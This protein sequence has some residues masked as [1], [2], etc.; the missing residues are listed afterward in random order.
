MNDHP[1]A[2][3][4]YVPPW[5]WVAGWLATSVA[6]AASVQHT[7]V[8]SHWHDDVGL[9]RIL[10]RWPLGAQGMISTALA[11]LVLWVPVGNAVYRAA[12]VANVGAAAAGLVFFQLLRELLATNA[13]TPRLGT[14]LAMLGSMLL[15]LGLPMQKSA[16]VAG[17]ASRSG[18]FEFERDLASC[19]IVRSNRLCQRGAPPCWGH[20]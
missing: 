18:G 19:T 20:S 15:T 13:H 17:G 8:S 12:L 5:P 9:I 1:K 4:K 14:W 7:G 10:A 2:N 16:T 3:S 11:Q 6:L